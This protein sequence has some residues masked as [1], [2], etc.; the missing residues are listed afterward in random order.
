MSS[1]FICTL[2]FLTDFTHYFS[3]LIVSCYDS[4]ATKND[5]WTHKKLMQP[6]AADGAFQT[7]WSWWRGLCPMCEWT[8]E[9]TKPLLSAAMMCLSSAGRRLT[10]LTVYRPVNRKPSKLRL[11][12]TF[13]AHAGHCTTF[14]IRFCRRI[15]IAFGIQGGPKIVGFIG[16]GWVVKL[17]IFMGLVGLG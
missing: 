2:I 5:S 17:Q 10:E 15:L 14:W 6:I 13:T 11:E 12:T 4:A 1:L 3:N 8:I 7:N 16:L 9:L